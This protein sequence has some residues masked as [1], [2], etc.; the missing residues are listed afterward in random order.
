MK[1]KFPLFILIVLIINLANYY[2]N[3]FNGG[4][5]LL[6]ISL[7]LI[8]GVFI[9]RNESHS[10]NGSATKIFL[11][12]DAGLIIGLLIIFTP[13]YTFY[14]HDL[15]VQVNADEVNI[16]IAMKNLVPI[17]GLNELFGK[18]NYLNLPML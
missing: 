4:L 16:M 6:W 2:L 18:S 5:F 15:P 17:S 7:L 11:R 10:L 3:G 12:K 8:S 13:L 1:K 9:S 14:L